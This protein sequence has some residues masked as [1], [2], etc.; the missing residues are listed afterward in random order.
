[1]F[2]VI[3]STILA[4]VYGQ[5]E[6]CYSTDDNPYLGFGSK[7]PYDIKSTKDINVPSGKCKHLYLNQ[8]VKFLRMK[9]IKIPEAGSSDLKDRIFQNFIKCER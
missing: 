2:L 5:N 7:S 1:M 4:S 3:F 6:Y 8:K 9:K